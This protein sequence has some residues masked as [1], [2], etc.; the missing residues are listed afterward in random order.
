MGTIPSNT[1]SLLP[2]DPSYTA[3]QIRDILDR[4]ANV[5][6]T[7]NDGWTP[8][9]FAACHRADLEIIRTLVS[10]GAD[11]NANDGEALSMAAWEHSSPEMIELL[12]AAGADVHAGEDDDGRTPLAYAAMSA[13]D[14]RVIRMLLDAG[15]DIDVRYEEGYTVLMLAAGDNLNPEIVRMF[16]N[17]GVDIN[18]V[19]QPEGWTAL[20]IAA[21][22]CKSQGIID[23]LLD[24]GAD[25]TLR[26]ADGK[27][28]FDY[29]EGRE[30]LKGT[31][32]YWR[33]RNAK[34]QSESDSM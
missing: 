26:C 31:D 11:V 3:T 16:V 1:P 20:M 18:A 9:M 7:I 14:P 22:A 6:E 23:A 8:L 17:A 21:Q 29:V 19:K 13:S 27:T 33:L 2:F 15:S 34:Y 32:A 28:A 5:N 25:A 24:A 30:W 12:L 10:A 4:G